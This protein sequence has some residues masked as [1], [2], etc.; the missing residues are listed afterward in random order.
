MFKKSFYKFSNSEKDF[1]LRINSK[2]GIKNVLN[3]IDK[4]NN[5]CLNCLVLENIIYDH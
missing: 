4:N 1:S 2:Y 3:S 5:L